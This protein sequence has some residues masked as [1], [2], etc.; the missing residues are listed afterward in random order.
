MSLQTKKMAGIVLLLVTIT[1]SAAA[2]LLLKAGMVSL[3]D[4]S[5]TS[6]SF[7][8]TFLHSS[9]IGWVLGGFVCYALSMLAWL[10]VLARFQL[11]YA[12]PLLGLS[13]VIVYIG[14]VAWPR[15]AEPLSLI[16]L[17]GILL[18]VVGVGL[19][20]VSGRSAERRVSTETVR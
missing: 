20:A 11:S 3:H 14:A 7:T 1:A 9:V 10:G 18:V 13:Y 16:R 17:A 4:L 19:V 5:V 8:D 12:Y 6:D 2:Q 15:L